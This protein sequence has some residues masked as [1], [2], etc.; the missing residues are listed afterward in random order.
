MKQPTVAMRTESRVTLVSGRR[1]WSAVSVGVRQRATYMSLPKTEYRW[2]LNVA[3]QRATR[4]D[5]SGR[6]TAFRCE[7]GRNSEISTED[8][9]SQASPEVT[10]DAIDEYQFLPMPELQT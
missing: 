5:G 3:N 1:W 7:R 2:L 9:D 4:R 8:E 6:R 10:F